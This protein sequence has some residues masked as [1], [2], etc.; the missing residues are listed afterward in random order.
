[1]TELRYLAARYGAPEIRALAKPEQ[2]PDD[3]RGPLM[4]TTAGASN[5]PD[6]SLAE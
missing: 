3:P 1:M 4:L 6:P 5:S 2:L